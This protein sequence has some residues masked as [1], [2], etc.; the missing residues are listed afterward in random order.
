VK[1]TKGLLVEKKE[2]VIEHEEQFF[3]KD[4]EREQNIFSAMYYCRD[5]GRK[6]RHCG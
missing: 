4:T 3:K 1:N 5:I 6:G 2:R